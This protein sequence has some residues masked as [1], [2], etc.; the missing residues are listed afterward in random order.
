[1][2]KGILPKIVPSKEE[3]EKDKRLADS[4]I[5]FIKKGFGV[6]AILVGSVAKGTAISGKKDLDIFLMFPKSTP[7]EV[8]EKRGNEIGNAVARF[9]GGKLERHYAEH[10]YTRVILENR[11]VEIVP[12]Y[13]IKKGDRVISAVDRTPLHTEYVLKKLKKKEDVILLKWFMKRIGVYGAEIRTHGFSGYLCELLVIAYGSFERV[14]EEASAWETPVVIDIDGYYK[15]RDEI[16][17]KFP[18][19]FVVID[20]VD[21]ERNV[22]SPVSLE[23]LS[24]F[25]LASRIFLETGRIPEKSRISLEGR[26]L[27]A[28]KWEIKR[29][30]EEIIWSQ[31]ESFTKKI[32]NVLNA[33][34]FKV[35]DYAYWT[36]SENL[37]EAIFDLETLSLP[38]IER[39]E[40]PSVFD[41]E[42]TKRFI[43]KH[44]KFMIKGS[45][46]VSEGEREYKDAVSLLRDLLD[47]S[48]KHIGKRYKIMMD[49]TEINKTEI[50]DIYSKKMWSI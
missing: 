20:P 13:K 39:K 38:R 21:K 2:D 33:Y 14:L 36:D 34:G 30:N 31:L 35:I 37:A 22:A 11:I 32:V 6:D 46:V 44:G 4:I 10:P 50:V 15:D 25:S 23:N 45:R 28:V 1:M 18:T 49:I 16:L 43:R 17:E 47:E 7:R 41:I 27:V 19:F 8:L 29:A 42:N 12:A 5:K 9:T 24:W 48:P 3:I 40:G 26:N